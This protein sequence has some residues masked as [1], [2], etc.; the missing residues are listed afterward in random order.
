M[1]LPMILR[2]SDNYLASNT[3]WMY[4]ISIIGTNPPSCRDLLRPLPLHP[5]RT[6]LNPSTTVGMDSDRLYHREDQADRY[7]PQGIHQVAMEVEGIET[8]IRK[9]LFPISPIYSFPPSLVKTLS[10]IQSLRN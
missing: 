7:P 5:A 4:V 9:V 8:A 3:Y 10:I 2:N 1:S 6:M